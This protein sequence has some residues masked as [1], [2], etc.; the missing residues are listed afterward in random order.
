MAGRSQLRPLLSSVPGVSQVQVL[1]GAVEEYRVTVD[2]SKL[3]A[4]GMTLDDVA[5][6]FP[7][8]MY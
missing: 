1:G 4:Y 5:R 2:P 6:Q 3:P 7:P 8:R